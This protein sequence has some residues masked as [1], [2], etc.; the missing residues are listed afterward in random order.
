MKYL[1]VIMLFPAF[2]FSQTYPCYTEVKLDTVKAE[3]IYYDV[4][5]QEGFIMS[6]TIKRDSIGVRVE[7]VTR[8]FYFNTKGEKTYW[9]FEQRKFVSGVKN[10]DLRFR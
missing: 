2:V 6:Q 8:L 10:V 3:K 7:E 9:D 1:F 5:N 4:W